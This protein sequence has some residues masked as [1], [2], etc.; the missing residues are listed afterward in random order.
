MTWKTFITLLV[1]VAIIAGGLIIWKKTSKEDNQIDIAIDFT[2][3]FYNAMDKGDIWDFDAY[4]TGL[5]DFSSKYPAFYNQYLYPELE[6]M[7]KKY[8]LTDDKL[9]EE[10]SKFSTRMRS[11]KSFNKKVVELYLESRCLNRP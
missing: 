7:K 2:C 11:D 8:D 3:S 1:L 4:T 6:I 5:K 10:H 9:F